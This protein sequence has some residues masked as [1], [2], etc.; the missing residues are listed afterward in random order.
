MAK[1]THSQE[2][3]TGTSDSYT[4]AELA[5]P[6]PPIVIQ[7]AVLGATG[8]GVDNSSVTTDGT[9]SPQSSKSDSESGETLSKGPQSPAQTT[10]S[11]SAGGATENSTVDL[12][13]GHGP[14]TEPLQSDEDDED[15]EEDIPPYEEW[16]VEDL[17][18]ECRT[19]KLIVSGNKTDL[20]KRLEANDLENQEDEDD[21]H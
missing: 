20:V 15:E 13:G 12:T 1:N 11:H 6:A 18:E 4:E 19:R 5:D 14:V 2:V 3:Q 8:N 9:D 17:R 21:N 7:R 16:N 10:E